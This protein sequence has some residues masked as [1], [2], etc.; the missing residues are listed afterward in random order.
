MS[1]SDSLAGGGRKPTTA[2]ALPK[3]TKYTCP[4]CSTWVLVHIPLR[5][6]PEC[7]RHSGGTTQMLEASK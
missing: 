5:F 4:K 1:Q 6:R 3:N 2:K 7:T